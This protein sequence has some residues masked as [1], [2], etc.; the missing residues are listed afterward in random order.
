MANTFFQ[1][2][3]DMHCSR[4]LRLS[5]AWKPERR[6]SVGWK[7][8]A[9]GGCSAGSCSAMCGLPW[10]S[11]LTL[12]KDIVDGEVKRPQDVN[13]ERLATRQGLRTAIACPVWVRILR[14]RC[15]LNLDE[16]YLRNPPLGIAGNFL[17][18][19]IFERRFRH[20]HH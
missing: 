4:T 13:A 16:P 15:L 14:H 3:H 20:L 7:A 19:V 2:F 8:S 11:P 18:A 10:V 6:R 9:A 5:R 17:V 1:C 12:P